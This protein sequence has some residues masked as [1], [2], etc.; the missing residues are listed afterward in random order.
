MIIFPYVAPS[1]GC[2]IPR[3]LLPNCTVPG[4]HGGSVGK[5]SACNVGDLGSISGR[6]KGTTKHSSILA[7]R[8]PWTDSPWSCKE[9][10]TTEHCPQAAQVNWW[11]CSLLISPFPKFKIHPV[12]KV[13]HQTELPA[14]IAQKGIVKLKWYVLVSLCIG[15]GGG[16]SPAPV[17]N[18]DINGKGI[19]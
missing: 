17:N 12:S 13:S 11:C 6:E 4:F 19:S 16:S 5:E 14:E 15:V 7:W 2:S 10:D 9:S 18:G 3:H 1:P 8:I